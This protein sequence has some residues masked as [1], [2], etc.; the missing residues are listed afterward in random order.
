MLEK[1]LTI[2]QLSERTRVSVDGVTRA[3]RN[4]G[5]FLSA[6][7]VRFADGRERMAFAI[8]HSSFQ[9]FLAQHPLIRDYREA[10]LDQ[11]ADEALSK[12]RPDS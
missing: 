7:N 8:Y 12:Y 2:A 6:Q 3:L 11:I 1:P 9:E 5:Q 10:V 4:W